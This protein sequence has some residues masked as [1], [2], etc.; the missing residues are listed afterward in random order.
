MKIFAKDAAKNS[1]QEFLKFLNVPLKRL[2]YIV[3]AIG[4]FTS[5]TIVATYSPKHPPSLVDRIVRKGGSI[6]LPSAEEFLKGSVE[7]QSS[8]ADSFINWT[9]S[10]TKINPKIVLDIPLESYYELLNTKNKALEFGILLDKG[11]WFKSSLRTSYSSSSIPIKLR[12]KGDW[13]DHL[14][15]GRWSFRI[16]TRKDSYYKGMKVFSIQPA[17]TRSYIFESLFHSFLK[18]ENLPH[19]RYD[20]VDLMVNGNN[21]GVYAVEEAFSKELIENSGFR[22]SVILRFTESN[23]FHKAL[24]AKKQNAARV[25][26]NS[27]RQVFYLDDKFLYETSSLQ[28][29]NSGEI[30]KNKN[31]SD[32]YSKAINSFERFVRKEQSMIDTFEYREWAK[33][34]AI[35]D[36]FQSWH[37]RRWHNLRLYFNPITGKF[38]PIGFDASKKYKLTN[39]PSFIDQFYRYGAHNYLDLFSDYRFA[40]EYVREVNRLASDQN[41]DK[42][43]STYNDFF[44]SQ[45]RVINSSFPFVSSMEDE[46]RSSAETLLQ[47]IEPPPDPFKIKRYIPSQ[48]GNSNIL[49]LALNSNHYL[50][51]EIISV[52]NNST[53]WMPIKG[54]YLPATHPKKL[55]TYRKFIFTKNDTAKTT[56][57]KTDANDQANYR[58]KFKTL[59]S[60]KVNTQLFSILNVDDQTTSRKLVSASEPDFNNPYPSLFDLNLS[61]K[62]L[63]FLDKDIVI[64]ST[65]FVPEGFRIEVASGSSVTF[66]PGAS[67]ISHSPIIVNG[68]SHQRV[69]FNG[70]STSSILISNATSNSVINYADFQNFGTLEDIKSQ[71][72]GAITF[73][74]SPVNISNTSFMNNLSEDSLNIFRSNFALANVTFKNSKSDALDVDFANGKIINSRF[75][76]TGNDALDFSGSNVTIDGVTISNA[77]DK[78]ISAGEGSNLYLNN[79]LSLDSSVGI[80]SKDSSIVKAKDLTF[81]NVDVCLAVFNKKSF[82]KG[83]HIEVDNHPAN[84]N[85]PYLVE[86]SSSLSI[87]NVSIADNSRDVDSLMYGRKFGKATQKR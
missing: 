46:I 23:L 51:I 1:N 42:F 83:G 77:S 60:N 62:V 5:T 70:S 47:S 9:N 68:K 64:D 65:I 48:D 40:R 35:S 25:N 63:S 87:D 81:R 86:K 3:P 43:F 82:F 45:L 16:K 11:N 52:E 22:E 33:F 38:I 73:Y 4:L 59:G 79:I 76:N 61:N 75:I 12:L 27:S 15:N 30:S 39:I 66:K 14:E 13:T 6:L 8:L 69:L 55:G 2:K 36:L 17:V 24:L 56:N 50:P 41:L 72:S 71:V 19:L 49:T 57:N 58:I 80:T 29:F 7:Y 84:C 37:T 53:V 20:F 85:V 44:N 34:Y 78:V 32:L 26:I 31:L 18:F 74:D 10:L 28:S 21:L 67:L 54:S